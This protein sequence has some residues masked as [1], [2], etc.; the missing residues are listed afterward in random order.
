[1][2]WKPIKKEWPSKP[3]T[4]LVTYRVWS[5]GEYLPKFESTYV[6][7]LRYSEGVFRLPKCINPE[8]EADMNKE[9]LAWM[10]LPEVYEE[11]SNV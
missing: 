1:M 7:I 11:E 5:K 9:V 3:G 10:E 8:A 4:Y 6:K 2:K